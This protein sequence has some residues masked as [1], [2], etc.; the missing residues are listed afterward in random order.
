ML[1]PGSWPGAFSP[2]L[3]REPGPPA[4][5]SPQ[6]KKAPEPQPGPHISLKRVSSAG[7]KLVIWHKT[8]TLELLLSPLLVTPA[9]PTLIS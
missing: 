9:Q 4:S 7:R 3:V 1:I 5:G 8:F 6:W 2:R